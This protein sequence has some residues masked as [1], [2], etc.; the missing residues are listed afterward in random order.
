[1]AE[2][3]NTNL[4]QVKSSEHFK[5][6]LSA[7][8]QRISLLYFWAPWA[9]PCKQM[10]EVVRELAR[11]Y[12]TLLSLQIEAEVNEEISESF[13]I[14]SVPSFIVLRVRVRVSASRGFRPFAPG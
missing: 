3:E 4:H 8:L 7:D 14:E 5:D 9:E 10:T 2:P 11:K 1:M 6:L 12:P 13:N